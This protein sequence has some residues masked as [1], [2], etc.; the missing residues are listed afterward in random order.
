MQQTYPERF[1]VTDHGAAV[2]GIVMHQGDDY[3]E[4]WAFKSLHAQADGT[5]IRLPMDLSNVVFDS[6]I[7]NGD[8]QAVGTLQ[9]LDHDDQGVLS[10]LLPGAATDTLPVGTYT[11][12]VDGADFGTGVRRTYV[13]GNLEVRR[14]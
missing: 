11:Y 1:G 4:K 9:I 13:K 8:G 3:A 10:V 5:F 14:K 2:L 12:W 6:L 7:S